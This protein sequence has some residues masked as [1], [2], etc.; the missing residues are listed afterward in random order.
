[1]YSAT[2]FDRSLYG[3]VSSAS[4]LARW[5]FCFITIERLPISIDPIKSLVFGILI[6]VYGL[7]WAICYPTVG[8]LSSNLG[9]ESPTARSLMYFVI[10]IP[11]AT[12]YYLAL[13]VMTHLGILPVQ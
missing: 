10:Y 3:V 9:I 12:V 8:V 5:Y 6:P 7:F 1:M 11:V 4:L 13:A 2:S